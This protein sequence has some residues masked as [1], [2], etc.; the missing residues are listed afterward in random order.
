K[1]AIERSRAHP[2]QPFTEYFSKKRVMEKNCVIQ[3]QRSGSEME[4][5]GIT[6]Y[7]YWLFKI[8]SI[9]FL[10][11][12]DR[13]RSIEAGGKKCC[14]PLLEWSKFKNARRQPCVGRCHVKKVRVLVGET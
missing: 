9:N 4:E 12:A 1:L 2:C 11:G 14:I 5:H 10:F 7:Y 13:M 8:S 3:V 6:Y